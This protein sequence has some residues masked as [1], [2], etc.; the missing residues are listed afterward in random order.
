MTMIDVKSSWRRV[1]WLSLRM[2]SLVKQATVATDR[3]NLLAANELRQDDADA[4]N[5]YIP[6]N[7]WDELSSN[8]PASGWEWKNVLL[9]NTN[10]LIPAELKLR[11]DYGIHFWWEKKSLKIRPRS[12]Q[13]IRNR[14]QLILSKKRLFQQ[15]F[16]YALGTKM[17]LLSP[18]AVFTRVFKNHQYYGTQLNIEA[19]DELMLR[20]RGLMPGNIYVGENIE[21]TLHRDV[22]LWLLANPYIWEKSARYNRHTAEDLSELAEAL[23]VFELPDQGDRWRAIRQ[24]FDW[25]EIARFCAYTILTARAHM[26][27]VHNLK[28]YVDPLSAKLHPIV[29]DPLMFYSGEDAATRPGSNEAFKTIEEC[30]LFTG[31]AN[32]FLHTFMEDP[33]FIGDVANVLAE[34]V[35]S[36][37]IEETLRATEAS[38]DLVRPFLDIDAL[39]VNRNQQGCELSNPEAIA[40]LARRN[41]E[42]LRKSLED[43]TITWQGGDALD[44]SVHGFAGARMHGIKIATTPK[45]LA[46]RVSILGSEITRDY[47]LLADATGT[48]HPKVPIHLNGGVTRESVQTIALKPV[49]YRVVFVADGS[50]IPIDQPPEFRD[51]FGQTLASDKLQRR[52]VR[53]SVITHDSR[54]FPRPDPETR[55]VGG[56]GQVVHLSSD[57]V[58]ARHQELEIPAGTTI[59]L[60]PGVSIVCKGSVSVRGTAAKPVT[61]RPTDQ[62]QP[63]GVFL[64]QGSKGTKVEITHAS[65]HGGSEATRG[66]VYYSGM[67][68]MHYVDHAVVLDSTFFDNRFGDDGLRAAGCNVR[69]ERCKFDACNS[70]GVDFDLCKGEVLDCQFSDN[71]ND[72]LDFMSSEVLVRNCRF[73]RSGDKGISCGEDS[74]VSI[75]SCVFEGNRI[76]IEAKDGSFVYVSGSSIANSLEFGINAY[77]KNWRYGDGGHVETN[78]CRLNNTHDARGDDRSLIWLADSQSTGSINS[79]CLVYSE[80]DSATAVAFPSDLGVIKVDET[81]EEDFLSKSDGWTSPSTSTRFEKRNKVLHAQNDAEI[82]SI[83]RQVSPLDRGSLR[84]VEL[85]VGCNSREPLEVAFDLADGTHKAVRLDM[86]T[87]GIIKPH[88]FQCECDIVAIHVKTAVPGCRLSLMKVRLW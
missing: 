22:L 68:S 67:L 37:E 5:I 52:T 46:A 80:K 76:G 51:V 26:D 78:N 28:F 54:L 58:I 7:S 10:T 32:R 47:E 43:V 57:L 24:R 79:A 48:W 19:I 41:T 82:F 60:D 70:D 65:M 23:A 59:Q 13:L 20:R 55:V 33:A 71:G 16:L 4:L 64:V 75:D 88:R 77:A 31:T 42:S 29:W 27:G 61:F 45:Q 85:L 14:S 62:E 3:A 40:N 25:D 1:E 9:G 72:A 11:G 30:D 12:E 15:H 6:E 74:K 17:G 18:E 66:G 2:G 21:N 84:T 36:N 69:L 87:T 56:D 49:S 73:E 8:L 50:A 86:A 83:S 81:F 35:A 34:V 38:F 39:D 53:G 44:L 63:W